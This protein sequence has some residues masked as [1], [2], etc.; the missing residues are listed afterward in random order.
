[1]ARRES[2]F[3]FFLGIV[4]TSVTSKIACASAMEAFR[5]FLCTRS[6]TCFPEDRSNCSCNVG[7]GR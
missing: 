1:M 3:A 4:K 6:S 2:V 7:S 5:I